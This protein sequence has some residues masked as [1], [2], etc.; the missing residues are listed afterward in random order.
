M[1]PVVA[2]QASEQA[3]EVS[4]DGRWIAYVSDD[5]GFFQVY[6]RPFLR[7]GG[8]TLVSRGAAIEP[9]WA[10]ENELTYVSTESDSLMLATLEF[11]ESVRVVRTALFDH[12]RFVRGSASYREYDISR[13]GQRFIFTRSLSQTEQL[14]PVVVRNWM[15]EVRRAMAAGSAR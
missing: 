6:L 12:S 11:G 4:P 14:L 9:A 10:S 3:G 2:T 13:D 7:P 8:R 15:E 1:Q 5:A